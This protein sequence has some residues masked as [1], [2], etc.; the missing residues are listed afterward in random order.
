MLSTKGLH[1]YSCVQR[2]GERRRR[3]SRG[4]VFKEIRP[5]ID[6]ETGDF[7]K[8]KLGGLP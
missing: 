7:V 6:F 1:I 2:S 8:K 3:V 4:T 5:G